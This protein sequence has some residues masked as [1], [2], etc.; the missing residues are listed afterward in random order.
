MASTPQLRAGGRRYPRTTGCLRSRTCST[1]RRWLDP[2]PLARREEPLESVEISY[3]RYRHGKNLVVH[4][5]VEID[6]AGSTPSRSR[7]RRRPLGRAGK[8]REPPAREAASRGVARSQPLYLRARA[9]GA[10]LLATVRSRP[11]GPLRA[12]SLTSQPA[13]T[14]R[15]RACS[16]RRR[17]HPPP[18]PATTPG[19]TPPRLARG[20]DLPVR[21]RLRRRGARAERVCR[22]GVGA[23]GTLRGSRARVAADGAGALPGTPARRV[24]AAREAGDVLTRLHASDLGSLPPHLP[25]DR[26]KGV[27]ESVKLVSSVVPALTERARLA[28]RAAPSRGTT[29]RRSRALSRRLPRRSAAR[30]R[31]RRV[32]PHRLRPPLRSRSR[33]RRRELRG[34]PR[35]PEGSWRRRRGVRSS[36]H[37]STATAAGRPGCRGI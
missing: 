12:A 7:R 8:Y 27:A 11:T 26:L 21:G 24:D 16:R 37:W 29:K 17:T 36:R 35:R 33:A 15:S 28:S 20:E 34:P 32:R 1:P 31:S 25:T 23:N 5:E 18:V 9:P 10:D 22:R 30:A 19:D 13:R 2:R 4:Y 3:L 14:G 6:G